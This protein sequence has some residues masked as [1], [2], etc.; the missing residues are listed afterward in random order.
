[1]I[2]VNYPSLSRALSGSLLWRAT[3]SS[4]AFVV[5]EWEASRVRQWMFAAA[6][7]L[8]LRIIAVVASIAG[9]I[10]LAAQFV[11][12][13]YVRSSLPIGW[14]VTAL[15]ATAV[16]AIW[17]EEFQRAWPRSFLRSLSRRRVGTTRHVAP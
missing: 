1:M 14:A 8:D 6:R 5:A 11:M 16:V 2:D 17:P 4:A 9:A 15:L 3:V 13:V 10:A 12:P 7:L